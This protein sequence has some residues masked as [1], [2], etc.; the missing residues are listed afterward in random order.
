M[1]EV[2]IS[3]FANWP[4]KQMLQ[5]LGCP[6]LP[7]IA[8]DDNGEKVNTN[9]CDL[10]MSWYGL[11]VHRMFESITKIPYS[12]KEIIKTY[13]YNDDTIQS[14]LNHYI[15]QALEKEHNLNNTDYMKQLLFAWKSKLYNFFIVFGETGVVSATAECVM[16]VIDHPYIVQMKK[17]ILDGKI[18]IDEGESL[19]KQFV[20]DTKDL[21]DNVFIMMC[22]TGGVSVNQGY[23]MTVIRGNVFDIS[24]RILPNAIESSYADGIVNL[25]DSLGE[26]CAAGVSLQSN[27]KALKDSEWLH[28][29]LHV[30][31]DVIMG[32]HDDYDCGSQRGAVIKIRSHALLRALEGKYV[33]EEDGTVTPIVKSNIKRWKVGDTIKIRST[34]FCDHLVDGKPCKTC[35]GLMKAAIPYNAIMQRSANLGM[36]SSTAIQRPV[37]QGL[38]SNKHFMRNSVTIPFEVDM[39]DSNIIRIKGSFERGRVMFKDD[40]DLDEN[41]IYLNPAMIREGTKLVLTA[42]F[43]SE[44]SDIINMESLN[45][46]NFEQLTSFTQ[47]TFV[48][49]E[50][51]PMLDTKCQIQR[52]ARVS[53][54]TRVS[55]LSKEFLEYV[56][57]NGWETVDK[58]FV[59]VDLSKLPTTCPVFFLPSVHEDLDVYRKEIESFVMFSGRNRQWMNSPV[60]EETFG[61]TLSE[62]WTLIDRKFKDINIIHAETM[63][64]A[65]QAHDPKTTYRLPSSEETRYFR[66]FSNCIQ[67]RGMGHVLIYQDANNVFGRIS[68][69]TMK[70][71]QAGQLECYWNVGV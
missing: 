69:Y 48:Y 21:D 66:S 15:Y 36:F 11:Q 3:E 50:T 25:A 59:H 26:K 40:G 37:G 42:A 10:M 13:I 32:I 2:K 33:F 52:T 57:E 8:T 1:I 56:M 16:E 7:A 65:L 55:K 39:A 43:A 41:F 5:W 22:K 23:Q 67:N 60:T 24:K 4:E 20:R 35:L 18:S 44:L 14:P 6:C 28:R 12:V 29:R 9:T 61:A 34:S 45:E 19:F 58:K 53:A 63:L 17:D 38:L 31:N 71:R 51:D 62:F 27:G 54:K 64:S 47:A 46:V 49:E 68:S 70:N 30:A